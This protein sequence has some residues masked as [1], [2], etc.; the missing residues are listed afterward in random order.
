M[1][2]TV[3]VT[4]A[5][6]HGG[7]AEIAE[8]IAA[9]ITASGDV[10]DVRPVAEV[11]DVARYDAVVLGSAVYYGRWRGD[12]RA[13]LRRHGHAL[14]ER[15]TWLF[16]SGPTGGSPEADAEVT[17]AGETPDSPVPKELAGAVERVQLRG[18]ATFPG[19][20]DETMNGLLERWMPR[21]DWRDLD[22]VAAWGVS[23]ASELEREI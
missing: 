5:S 17:R 14:R 12:A 8:R 9:A 16:S 4:Y 3:L 11:R 20:V 10:A 19:R 18:H 2:A 21:G 7:T 13:F 15:P 23:I 6:K 1:S 22:R